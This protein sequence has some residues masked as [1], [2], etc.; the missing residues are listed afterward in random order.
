[1]GDGIYTIT[2]GSEG[3]ALKAA[4][5]ELPAPTPEPDGSDTHTPDPDPKP[6]PKPEPKPGPDTS[7]T[8]EDPQLR[9]VQDARTDTPDSSVLPANPANAAVQDAHALPQTGTSLFAALA[10]A[11]SGFALTIAG[12]WSSLL[13]KNSRH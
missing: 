5:A 2:A 13:G 9:P 3:L 12:A 8:P 4:H 1:M 7:V 11:L 6:E 10:M